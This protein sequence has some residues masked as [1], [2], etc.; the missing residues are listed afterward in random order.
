MSQAQ[1]FVD[2]LRRIRSGD[3]DAT[4]ELVRQ[5]E[6][7]IRLEVRRRLNDPSLSPVLGS[8]DICQSV[9]ASFF[10]RVAGGQ[11]D[12]EE[13]EQLLGL[14]VARTRNKLA[15]HV[16]A[17]SPPVLVAANLLRVRHNLSAARVGW[18]RC[19]EREAERCWGGLRVSASRLPRI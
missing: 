1:S 4:A 18:A 6:P 14:L 12:L 16:G 3:Q 10:V 19:C 9:L 17:A 2:F 15:G 13:P 5:Y 7:A 11:F 8:M